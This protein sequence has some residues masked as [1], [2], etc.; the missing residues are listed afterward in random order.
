[1]KVRRELIRYAHIALA[2]T[3]PILIVG[4]ILLKDAGEGVLQVFG[5]AVFLLGPVIVIGLDERNLRQ[6]RDQ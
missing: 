2:I 4:A 5:L 3:M 6:R 1:M